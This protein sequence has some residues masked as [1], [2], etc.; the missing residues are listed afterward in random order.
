[1][2]RV[3]DE[4]LEWLEENVA[5]TPSA[6]ADGIDKHPDYV[7]DHLRKLV[8]LGLL[9]KPSRG[10]YRIND[11]GEEYLRGELDASELE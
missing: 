4:I 2:T 5:G 11:Q 7:G 9:D 6:V 3:D 10:Y 8:D 1:M